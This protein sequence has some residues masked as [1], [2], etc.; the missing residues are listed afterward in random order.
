M[1]MVDAVPFPFSD[2]WGRDLLSLLT[3]M[4]PFSDTIGIVLDDVGIPRHDIA[5]EGRTGRAIWHDV[6]ADAAN[7]GVVGRL[8]EAALADD[9]LR[10]YHP[11]LRTLLAAGGPGAAATPAPPPPPSHPS[12]PDPAPTGHAFLSYVREDSDVIDRLEN[13]LTAAGI[14]VWRDVRN[15]WPGDDWKREIRSAIETGSCAFVVCFSA[16]SRAREE[17]HQWEE[18]TLA[19]ES[20]RKR[21]PGK[22]WI[23]PVR[24]DDTRPPEF[25]LGAGRRLSDLN[26]LDFFGARQ[27]DNAQRLVGAIKRAMSR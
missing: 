10:A 2:P 8:L 22:S 18:L 14:A 13:H 19:A 4:Y 26:Y 21:P 25:D 15:L 16:N 17:T 6:L 11:E 20:F 3:R 12:T 9:G 24:L 23:Y 1:P 5:L 7:R 27:D